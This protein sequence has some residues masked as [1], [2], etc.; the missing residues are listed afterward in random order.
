MRYESGLLCIGAVIF[1]C[2]LYCISL[3]SS[4]NVDKRKLVKLN[5]KLIELCGK[6][7]LEFHQDEEWRLITEIYM[8]EERIGLK[9][10]NLRCN[11]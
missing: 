7:P 10:S 6:G 5:Q 11:K 4:E 3:S 1:V 9:K 2:L 8:S